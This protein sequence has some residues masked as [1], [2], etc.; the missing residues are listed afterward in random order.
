[1]STP[2][3]LASIAPLALILPEAV[4]WPFDPNVCMSPVTSNFASLLAP[5][6]VP[7]VNPLLK[8]ESPIDDIS[9]VLVPLLYK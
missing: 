2:T 1:M 8:N 4:I 5:E 6:P 7:T 9:V 3:L